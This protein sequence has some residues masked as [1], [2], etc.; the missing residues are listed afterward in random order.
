MNQILEFKNIRRSRFSKVAAFLN[1]G[2]LGEGVFLA[3]G[4]LRTLIDKKEDVSDFDVFFEPNKGVMLDGQG[5]IF[6]GHARVIQTRYLL[7]KEKF[8]CIFECPAGELYTYVKDGMKI[9]LITVSFRPPK[10]TILSFD[11]G[12]CQAAYD[13]GTFIC[14]PQFIRNIITKKLSVE[15]VTFPVATIKRMLKYAKKGYNINDAAVEFMQKV[16]GITF[17][18]AD[19]RLYLD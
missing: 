7:E 16:S 12:A 9:Q 2:I 6:I 14:T 15:L 17:N 1:L 5:N 11:F 3:G 4:A 19:L 18:E 10:E 13:G 8:V